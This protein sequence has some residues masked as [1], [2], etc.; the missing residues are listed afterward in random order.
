MSPRN[1]TFI[2]SLVPFGL[3][4]A[5]PHHFLDMAKVAW[6]NRNNLAYAWRILRHG[7]C[8]GCSLGPR[9]LRD[10]TLDGIHLCMSRLKL[11]RLNTM[12]GL[13]TAMLSD[14]TG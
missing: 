1:R 6:E 4:H 3:G 13:D 2:T 7:V 8:D 10:D 5:K 12:T 14:V 11:L 9:G